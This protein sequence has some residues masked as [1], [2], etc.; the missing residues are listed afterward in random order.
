MG[1]THEQWLSQLEEE[2]RTKQETFMNDI[3]EKLKRKRVTQKPLHPFRGAPGFWNEFEWTEEERTTNFIE[4]FKA[5]GGHPVRLT[6]MEEAKQFI[7]EKANDL[8][9]R[10][11]IHQ[12]QPELLEFDLPFSLPDAKISVWN[13]DAHEL[14]KARAAEAD[15]GI[16]IADYAV[17]Y[18][19]SMALLSSKEKGRSVS[20]LPTVLMVIIPKEKIKTKLGEVLSIFDQTGRNNMPAGVHFV[21]GP[22]RSADIENDLTIGVH[23]PGIVYALIVESL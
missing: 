1:K 16:V 19:G 11:I 7:L 3:A 21:S 9:A 17:A 18:T 8:V 20:L 2:S 10:Y 13:T 4:N 5:A 12:N 6:T 14:W 23:G 22:S 15:M